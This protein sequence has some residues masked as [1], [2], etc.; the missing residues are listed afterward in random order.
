MYLFNFINRSNNFEQYL[1]ILNVRSFMRHD[2]K[3]IFRN[4]VHLWEFDNHDYIHLY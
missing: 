3:M 2:F 4:F 1:S